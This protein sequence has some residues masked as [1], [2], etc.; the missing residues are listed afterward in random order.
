MDLQLAAPSL[1]E[2]VIGVVLFGLIA[3]TCVL[4]TNLR[5][6]AGLLKEV[7]GS[8]TSELAVMSAKVTDANNQQTEAQARSLVISKHLQRVEEKQQ[9]LESQVR[10]LKFQDPSLKLYQRAADLVKKGASI[11]E[12]IESCDIPRAEAEMLV[13]VHKSQK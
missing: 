13:M 7:R 3:F 11:E 12:I 10:D 5:R 6:T 4:Y 8:M 1:V 9:E 2:I